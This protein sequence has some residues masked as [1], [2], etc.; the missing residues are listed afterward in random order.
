MA[1]PS[2]QDPHVSFSS[3]PLQLFVYHSLLLHL[4]LPIKEAP[5]L[6]LNAS[7]GIFSSS[8]LPF[9]Y[10]SACSHFPSPLHC[11]FLQSWLQK[12][13][14][15]AAM[16]FPL[17]MTASFLPIPR[18]I[19]WDTAVTCPTRITRTHKHAC[20]HIHNPSKQQFTF[21]VSYLL[22]YHY[23]VCTIHRITRIF[24]MTLTAQNTFANTHI[25]QS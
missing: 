16:H 7:P 15:T 8:V 3:L 11:R 6:P 23:V 17:I 10:L 19:K 4:L 5:S 20:T 13:G 12:S 2:L 1:H 25:V 22:L 9:I 18:Q 24:Y 14:C 21:K